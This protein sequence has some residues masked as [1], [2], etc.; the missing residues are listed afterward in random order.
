LR[1]I[2]GKSS[3]VDWADKTI[4]DKHIGKRKLETI[5][6]KGKGKKPKR[7]LGS[8]ESTPSPG[9]SPPYQELNG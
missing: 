6:K 9:R 5:T 4:G 8:D 3:L 1:K 7:V 2:T